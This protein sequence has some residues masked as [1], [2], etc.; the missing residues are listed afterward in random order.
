MRWQIKFREGQG[1]E[2]TGHVD[3]VEQGAPTPGPWIGAGPCPIRNWATQ[4][5]R[6]GR[7]KLHLYLRPRPAPASPPQRRLGSSG[8]R[9][10]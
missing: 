4:Q 3:L 5:V 8:V 1:H 7:A 10:S 2:G 9:F 6:G